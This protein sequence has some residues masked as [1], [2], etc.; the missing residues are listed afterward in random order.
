MRF[1]TEAQHYR[2]SMLPGQEDYY[3]VA[4]AEGRFPDWIRAWDARNWGVG[5]GLW[6]VNYGAKDRFFIG[7]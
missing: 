7:M 1:H 4:T 3:Q 2:T 5:N 6:R